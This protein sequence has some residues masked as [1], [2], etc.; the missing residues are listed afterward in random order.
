MDSRARFARFAWSVLGWNVFVILWGTFVRASGSGAGCGSHWP[1]CNGEIVPR[2]P[3]I[4]TIIEFTHRATSGLALLAV[5][6][7]L[8]WAFRL[9]PKPHPARRY[10]ALSLILILVEAALGA[11]L[12]LFEFVAH[13]PSAGRAL[14]LSAH[15]TNTLLLMAALAATAW[16]AGQAQPRSPLAGAVSWHWIGI[17]AVFLSGV[18]GVIAALGDTLWPA[19]SLAEGVR[20]EFS[21]AS[22]ALLRLRLLH[23]L[24][25]VLAGAVLGF[26]SLIGWRAGATPTGRTAARWLSSLTLVQFIAG[27][28]NVWLLAPV[29]MQ[30]TH[31]L[32]AC[33]LWISLLLMMF[34]TPPVTAAP[35]NP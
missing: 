32:L 7:L 20:G 13:N 8:V 27:A 35:S 25:A 11:G 2:A 22:P 34:E 18:T 31:L 33:L 1:L 19:A 6:A 10:A 12:V 3:A 9:F 24:L 23:P 5:A 26:V 17:A 14:Y 4:E 30:V 21:S 28:V 16:L 15:L 29:W